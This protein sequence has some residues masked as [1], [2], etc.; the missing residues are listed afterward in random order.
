MASVT[1]FSKLTAPTAPESL[2]PWPGSMTTI[3]RAW[4]AFGGPSSRLASVATAGVSAAGGMALEANARTAAA[5]ATMMSPPVSA[6]VS[7]IVEA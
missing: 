6:R 3:L 7:T 1:F 4:D 2:P 5:G